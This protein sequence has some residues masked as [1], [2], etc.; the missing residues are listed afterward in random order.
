MSH[1]D[2]PQ[3]AASRHP[4]NPDAHVEKTACILCSRNCGLTV[5]I[6]DGKFTRIRGD[7]AHPV[8]KGYICQKAARLD[9]YQNHADRL[10][11]PLQR[12]ADGS[13]KRVSWDEALDDIVR[14]LLAIREQHGG[15]AFAF[16]GGGGQGNHLGGMY[17]QQLLKAMRSRFVYTS[18]AQEKT[19]DFWVNGR[20]FG[21]QTCHTTEDVEHADYVLFIGT[22]P[23]QAH[24]IPNARDTLRDLQKNSATHHGGG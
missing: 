5:T 14:R 11:Y 7:E 3:Q 22:N 23:Y 2:S 16:Y 8:S 12:Q 18:L 13:F 15:Q 1:S 17:S 20:L 19:G 6:E 9:Y 10:Q 4:Q 21:H 24:G